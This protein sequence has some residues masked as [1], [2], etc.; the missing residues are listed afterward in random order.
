MVISGPYAAAAPRTSCRF[1]LVKTERTPEN[2]RVNTKRI[3]MMI[4]TMEPVTF[5][6]VKCHRAYIGTIKRA[7]IAIVIIIDTTMSILSGLDRI[8]AEES[9]SVFSLS[10]YV[11]DTKVSIYKW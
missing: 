5:I 6:R 9:R 3:L 10:S 8:I 4:A 2:I 1:A 11:K 7:R